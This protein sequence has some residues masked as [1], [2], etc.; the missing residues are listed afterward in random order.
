MARLKPREAVVHLRERLT[1]EPRR[2]MLIRVARE[3]IAE[4]SA[5]NDRATGQ[6][7]GHEVIVDG[8]R[9][10]AIESVKPGGVVVALFAVRAAAIDFT[11]EAL[12]QL[13]PV[14]QN[15]K[16]VDSIVYRDRHLLLVNGEEREPPVDVQ[17]DD[18]VTFVNLLPYARKIEKGWSKKQAPDGVYEAATAIVKARFGNIVDVRFSYGTFLGATASRDTRYPYIQ[19]SPKRRR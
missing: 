17:P 19:L 18:I 3:T 8:R 6:R 5:I 4:V 2:Q 16:T 14:D 15:P 12:A 11:W 1:G 9:G 13:S 10:A 7:V